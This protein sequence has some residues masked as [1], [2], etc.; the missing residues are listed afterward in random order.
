MQTELCN[1]TEASQERR[2]WCTTHDSCQS[3]WQCRPSS[4]SSTL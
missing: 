1:S 3:G 2:Q 4:S